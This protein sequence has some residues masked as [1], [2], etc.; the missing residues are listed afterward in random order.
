VFGVLAVF[1][2]QDVLPF[3]LPDLGVLL[4][5]VV[6]GLA[7]AAAVAFAAFG[8]DVAGRSFGWRQP[9]GLAALAAVAV[10]CIPVVLTVTDGAFYA[11]RSTLNQITASYVGTAAE[12]DEE[13]G[14][15]LY[16]G[17][18]RLLPVPATPL[19]GGVS[20]AVVDDGPLDHRDRS[21]ASDDELRADLMTVI[22][23]VA[24]GETAR[25]GRL[26]APFGVRYI[27]VPVVDGVSSTAADPLPVAT[28]LVEALGDQLDLAR[29]VTPA[30]FLVFENVA[31]MP[32]T[33]TI[34]GD[35][36]VASRADTLDVL[37]GVDPAGVQPVL[38]GADARRT[39]TDQV[40]AGTVHVGIAPDDLWRLEVDGA[41]IEARR[42]FGATTAFDVAAAGSATLEYEPAPARRWSLIGVGALWL[43]ALVLA[44]RLGVPAVL[45]RTRSRDETLLD[46]DAEPGAAD[47]SVLDQEGG[48]P[49]EFASWVDEML[50]PP[51]PPSA[52][53]APLPPPGGPPSPPKVDGQPDRAVDATEERS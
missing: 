7:L 23:D 4:A 10:G 22:A 48:P 25:G 33:S 19:G 45:R 1:Q 27:V 18:P 8:D 13:D 49:P 14:R 16:L 30:A 5:P 41:P 42:A 34:D 50:P 31:A 47:L 26:L 3:R 53:P 44:S 12:D 6:V 15:V 28:G 51:S 32:T 20:L 17:D 52:A 38:V 11:P 9:V 24:A 46:L 36:A 43:V 2:D 37:V 21:V 40:P 29:V 39:A 35:L